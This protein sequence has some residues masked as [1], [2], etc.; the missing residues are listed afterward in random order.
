MDEKVETFFENLKTNGI[1]NSSVI[2]LLS[3]H[4]IRFGSIRKTIQGW[5]E[6]RLPANLVSIP[7]WFQLKYPEKYENLQKNAKK[8]TSTYDV[9]MT[10]QEL[11]NLSVKN[12][13]ITA[14]EACPTCTS[15]FSDIPDNRSCKKAGIPEL[16]CTCIGKFEE[17]STLITE[18]L[19]K[20]AIKMIQTE[21]N[22]KNR[23]F[24]QYVTK[25]ILSSINSDNEKKTYYLIVVETSSLI[26]YQALFRVSGTP[27][28]L[29]KLIKIIRLY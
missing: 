27:L 11:L 29:E 18:E 4:G 9:Y 8:L 5:Y 1:F 23:L 26:S 6:E 19:Q 15:L 14:S 7:P 28:K 3:D 24:R 22:S 25:V 10:L 2:F 20:E 21:I 16:W 13:N 17:N 12:H